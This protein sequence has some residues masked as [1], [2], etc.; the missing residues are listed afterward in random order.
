MLNSGSSSVK[1]QLVDPV[2]GHPWRQGIVERI[3]EDAASAEL[4]I[5]ERIY[6][7]RAIADHEPR[8]AP[9][10]TTRE[11]GAIWGPGWSRSG[12]GWCTAAQAS[13]SRR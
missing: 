2:S 7:G 10:S 3:G 13:T 6:A 12:I 5:G 8:C 11:A 1:F 4:T 9:C